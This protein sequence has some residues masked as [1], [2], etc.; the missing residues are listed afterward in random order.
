MI[1]YAKCYGCDFYYEI[2]EGIGV[3]PAQMAAD[4]V[5]N[6]QHP[7]QALLVPMWSVEWPY[8]WSAGAEAARKGE[9]PE[10]PF[11]IGIYFRPVNSESPPDLNPLGIGSGAKTYHLFPRGARLAHAD[12]EA[13]EAAQRDE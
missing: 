12:E 5:A 4:H 11:G 6:T 1:T 8:Y 2:T 7:L 9:G 13:A 3:P 10:P